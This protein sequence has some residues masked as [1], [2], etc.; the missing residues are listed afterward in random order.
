MEIPLTEFI[1]KY[2]VRVDKQGQKTPIRLRGHQRAILEYIEECN[3]QIEEYSTK[4]TQSTILK[5]RPRI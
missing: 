2:T 3:K 5:P 4:R 1:E